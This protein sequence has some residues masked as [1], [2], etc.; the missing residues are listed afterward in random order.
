M[1]CG[2]VDLLNNTI[3]LYSGETKND[4]GRMVALTEECR[5]LVTE[6]RRGKQ[7]EDFLITRS[8]GEHVKDFRRAWDLLVK[9]AGVPGLLFHDLRRSAARNMIRRGV[10]QKT[11][12]KIS[13]HKT[14]SVFARYNIV[15]E[16]DIQD[17]AR[18][19]EEGAKAAGLIH[20]S[21]IVEPKP[22]SATKDVVKQKPS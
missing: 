3:C 14:D 21:F 11:A 9:A 6:L 7:P 15:N 5:Q 2:Q 8:N 10:P 4:E 20:S 1:R 22:D 17:A 12:C 13:G 19:I 16:A 18:K